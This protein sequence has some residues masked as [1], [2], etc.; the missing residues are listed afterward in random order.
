MKHESI[1]MPV[2]T[3][4]RK[5]ASDE[6]LYQASCAVGDLLHLL[7]TMTFVLGEEWTDPAA[8]LRQMLG[9]TKIAREA[10]ASTLA[11]MLLAEGEGA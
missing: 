4:P 1:A 7:D 8:T 9:C 3:E 6:V 10:V 5:R 2:T 11:A